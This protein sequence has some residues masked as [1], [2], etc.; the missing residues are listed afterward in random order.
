M[1]FPA[2]SLC[3]STTSGQVGVCIFKLVRR[4]SHTGTK[5]KRS[6]SW[7]DNML[8]NKMSLKMFLKLPSIQKCVWQNQRRR[9][10][11]EMWSGAIF[12]PP[13]PNRTRVVPLV[14][15]PGV[16]ARLHKQSRRRLVRTVP[17]TA[18]LPAAICLQFDVKTHSGSLRSSEI[19][20]F[21]GARLSQMRVPALISSYYLYLCP[22]P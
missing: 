21:W 15:L 5:R 17:Q 10:S 7:V 8:A 4:W 6:F 18:L 14:Q 19:S 13:P 11:V 22:P 2:T 16:T 9:A 3:F 20:I 1:A 12:A